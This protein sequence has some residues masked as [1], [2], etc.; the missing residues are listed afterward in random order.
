MR[1]R[2]LF[3]LPIL[4]ILGIVGFDAGCIY[5]HK[6]WLKKADLTLSKKDFH[7]SFNQIYFFLDKGSTSAA[8]VSEDGNTVFK[9]F[10]NKP[11]ISHSWRRFVPYLS[12][13][14]KTRKY[15]KRKRER[16]ASC[17][18]AYNLFP[19]ETALVYYHLAPT[20]HLKQ[21][22]TLIDEHGGHLI[23][24][25]DRAEY[26]I[27]KKAIVSSAFFKTADL[28]LA[29]KGL[30]SLLD[31]TQKLHSEGAVMVD[32]QFESNFGFIDNQPMRLD[33]E[34]LKKDPAWIKGHKPHLKEQLKSFRKWLADNRP[35]L[36]DYLD[37]QTKALK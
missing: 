21:K 7:K 3:W 16:A 18:N 20:D 5:S 25:L 26:Y 27:Q 1:Y 29:K 32:L 6:Q 28:T 10:L 15:Y 33:I 9:L 22:I 8:F 12:D 19:K 34:H 31:F 35:D 4:L 14:S 37:T 30:K 11:L 13:L 23:V 36:I 2:Y 17:M 24:D